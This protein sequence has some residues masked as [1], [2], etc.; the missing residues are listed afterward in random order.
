MSEVKAKRNR[1]SAIGV[2]GFA[3]FLFWWKLGKSVSVRRKKNKAHVR[4]LE[5]RRGAQRVEAERE[6]ESSE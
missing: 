3:L 5:K 6:T 4:Q 2:Y 1:E